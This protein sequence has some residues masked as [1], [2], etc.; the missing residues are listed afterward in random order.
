MVNTVNPQIR[1]IPL[2]G[3]QI[4]KFPMKIIKNNKHENETRIPEEL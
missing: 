1:D 2:S 3:Y 4:K